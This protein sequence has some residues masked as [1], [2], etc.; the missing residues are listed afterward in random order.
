M[1]VYALD[2]WVQGAVQEERKNVRHRHAQRE[3]RS[4]SSRSE[5]L[6]RKWE[7]MNLDILERCAVPLMAIIAVGY[8]HGSESCVGN[9]LDLSC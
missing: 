6:R 4:S 2:S 9:S 3:E 7:E 8:D 1:C 5:G